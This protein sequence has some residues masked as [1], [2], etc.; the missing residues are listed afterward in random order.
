V[1]S[2]EPSIPFGPYDKGPSWMYASRLFGNIA[3]LDL[4]A[5]VTNFWFGV[6]IFLGTLILLSPLCLPACL[7]DDPFVPAD[8][9]RWKSFLHQFGLRSSGKFWVFLPDK[10]GDWLLTLTWRLIRGFVKERNT[11]IQPNSAR[12]GTTTV[13]PLPT[14]GPQTQVSSNRI[15]ASVPL[16]AAPKTGTG[17]GSMFQPGWYPDPA[18]GSR[19]WDGVRWTGEN[20]KD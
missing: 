18:R 1:S 16:P 8:H 6:L 11:V 2:V 9:K 12:A 7:A 13:A 10:V 4:I 3:I 20:R 19:Y 14:A 5:L 15:E 17:S